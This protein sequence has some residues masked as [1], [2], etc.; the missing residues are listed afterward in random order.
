[1]TI[2]AEVRVTEKQQYVPQPPDFPI[3]RDERGYLRLLAAQAVLRG[4]TTWQNRRGGSV[5]PESVTTPKPS[6]RPVG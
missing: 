3:T 4:T 1:V 5:R 6:A 2:R